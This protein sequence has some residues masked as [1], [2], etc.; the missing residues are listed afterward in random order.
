MFLLTRCYFRSYIGNLSM[1]FPQ[2]YRYLHP[3]LQEVFTSTYY[4]KLT[5]RPLEGTGG[6][7]IAL[8]T[9]IGI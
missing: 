2:H 1:H 9:L 8:H 4:A 6:Y 3:G 5:Q 7:H